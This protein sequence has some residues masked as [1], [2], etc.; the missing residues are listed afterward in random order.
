V[1]GGERGFFT[2]KM[3]LVQRELKTLEREGGI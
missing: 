1:D 3:D 2:D